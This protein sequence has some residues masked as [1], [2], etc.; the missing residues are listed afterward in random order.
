[1]NRNAAMKKSNISAEASNLPTRDYNLKAQQSVKSDDEMSS[2]SL[3]N[4]E[5]LCFEE[6]GIQPVFI[7]L[8]KAHSFVGRE[9]RS[10]HPHLWNDDGTKVSGVCD[11]GTLK[12]NVFVRN[13]SVLDCDCDENAYLLQT[14]CVFDEREQMIPRCVHHKNFRMFC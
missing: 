7:K 6:R 9:C 8:G 5:S 14:L 4:E 10:F 13:P 1:M 3:A 12:T 11:P 2:A